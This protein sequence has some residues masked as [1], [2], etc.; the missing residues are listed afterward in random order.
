MV[1]SVPNIAYPLSAAQHHDQ[2][3][4]TY[5]QAYALQISSV[6]AMSE[7][8]TYS[9]AFDTNGAFDTNARTIQYPLHLPSGFLPTSVI[10]QQP[11]P[12][13]HQP[14]MAAVLNWSDNETK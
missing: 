4:V 6:L 11:L 5:L 14:S 10:V 13:L 12:I 1:F 2:S 3:Q 8:P 9:L 7:T